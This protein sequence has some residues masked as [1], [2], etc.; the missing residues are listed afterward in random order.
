VRGTPADG[1]FLAGGVERSWGME[2]VEMHEGVVLDEP[3]V[4]GSEDEEDAPNGVQVWRQ[5]G[6]LPLPKP[7]M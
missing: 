5:A 6:V 4:P 1:S 2:D 3:G 7:K